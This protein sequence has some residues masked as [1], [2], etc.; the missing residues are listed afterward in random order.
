MGYAL[1]A[2][3]AVRSRLRRRWVWLAAIV[4][5]FSGSNIDWTSGSVS[6]QPLRFQLF[7][8]GAVKQTPYSPWIFLCAVPVGAIFFLSMRRRFIIEEPTSP[9]GKLLASGGTMGPEKT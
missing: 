3:L 7:C 4:V 6:F 5:G 1:R 8:L 2:W 9:L